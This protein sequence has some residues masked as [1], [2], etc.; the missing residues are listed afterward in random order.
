MN[1]GFSLDNVGIKTLSF[2]DF[3][4]EG[5][6]ETWSTNLGSLIWGGYTD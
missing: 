1:S 5:I 6:G 4:C 2:S 3:G